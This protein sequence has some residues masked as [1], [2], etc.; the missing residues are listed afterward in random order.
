MKKITSDWHNHTHCSCDS[1]CMEFE[2]YITDAK[3]YGLKSFGVSDHLHALNLEKDIAAS[4]Q[5]YEKAMENHP[6]LQRR[7]YFG[8]EASIMSQWEVNKIHR[9]DYS[10]EATYGIRSGGPAND[11]PVLCVDDEFIEKYH[12]DYVI[13]GVHW[14]LYCEYTPSAVVKDYFRQYLFAAAH[15][16]TDILAHFCW[17]NPTPNM[18]NPFA[19][20][21]VISQSMRSEL[22]AALLENNVVFEL[23]IGSVTTDRYP[24]HFIEEYLGWAAELQRDGVALSYG[25]DSHSPHLYPK[26]YAYAEGLFQKHGI[27]PE[28]FF[29]L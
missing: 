14:T 27:D 1:A 10:G 4:R 18:T 6:E 15:P 9:G 7:F 5:E 23:N 25:T 28:K 16:H 2:D 20:F 13:S 26:D 24:A 8:V 11:K 3:N 17:W 21:S 12:I 19:D 22:K 29:T